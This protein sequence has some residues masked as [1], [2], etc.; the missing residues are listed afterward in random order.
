MANYKAGL[1]AALA[2]ACGEAVAQP[3]DAWRFEAM[4]YLW[5]AGYADVGAGESDSTW[6]VSA[7][8]DY[9]ISPTATTK[10]GY[11]YFK[12]GYQKDDLLWNMASAGLYLGVGVRF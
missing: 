5:A 12:V 1:A 10:F 3:G 9:A 2:L 11:R 7:G 4:P 6:Q 8:V